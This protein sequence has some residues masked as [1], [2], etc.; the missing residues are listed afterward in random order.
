M[1]KKSRVAFD[2]VTP[3]EIVR[4]ILKSNREVK[5]MSKFED[6]TIGAAANS[7]I[8]QEV[9]DH[10]DDLINNTIEKRLSDTIMIVRVEE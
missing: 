4:F 1:S 10:F 9:K 6:R 8:K 5:M 2:I 7:L 3:N